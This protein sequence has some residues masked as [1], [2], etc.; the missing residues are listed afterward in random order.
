MKIWV[1]YEKLRSK[2]NQIDFDLKKDLILTCSFGLC[3]Y[4]VNDTLDSL[5]KKADA[6]MYAVKNEYKR[7]K[8]IIA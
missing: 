3:Q 6:S 7:K 8:N 4:E 1:S 5:L 2:I